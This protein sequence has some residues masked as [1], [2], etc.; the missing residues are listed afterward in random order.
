MQHEPVKLSADSMADEGHHLRHIKRLYAVRCDVNRAMTRRLGRQE[1]VRE[2]CRILVEVGEFRFACF[3]FSAAGGGIP[4]ATYGDIPEGMKISSSSHGP[5]RSHPP[6]LGSAAVA[7][8]PVQ[9]PSGESGSLVLSAATTDF[10][11]D[12][13]V[14]LLAEI[15]ADVEYALEFAESEARRAAVEESMERERSLFKT[16]VGTI[17]DLVW[18]KDPDGTYLYCNPAFERFFGASLKE[19]VGRSDY[20]FVDAEL[21]EFFRM[22]DREALATDRPTKNDEWVTFPDDGHRALL[23]T[24]KSPLRDGSGRLVGVLGIARDVTDTRQVAELEALLDQN[25]RFRAIFDA[26]TEGIVVVDTETLLQVMVNP[27]ACAM[28]GYT[29]E[30]FLRLGVAGMHPAALL[31]AVMSEFRELV[32]GEK[33]G[34]TDIP[35][36][37]R[38]GAIF[39]ANVGSGRISL[40][41]R[42]CLMG[43]FSDI[44]GR[45]RAE[46]ELRDSEQKFRTFSAM[47]MDGIV[48]LDGGGRVTYWNH[49]AEHIFGFSN[50]EVMGHHLHPLIVPRDQGDSY[51]RGLEQFDRTGTGPLIDKTYE[52]RA[53]HKNGGEFP[54]EV[55]ISGYQLRGRW[56]AVGIIRDITRRKRE[57]AVLHEQAELLRTGQESLSGIIFGANLGTWELNLQNGA[58][59]LNQRWAEMI[60]YTLEEL[61]PTGLHTLRE[62]TH[63]DDFKRVLDCFER[64]ING[65]SRS[66]E[67]E[68]RMRHKVGHWVWIHDRGKIVSRDADGRPLLASGT[69]ADISKRKKTEQALAASEQSLFDIIA[70]AH[71]GTWEWNL[72]SGAAKFNERWAEMIGYRLEELEPNKLNTLKKHTHLEDLPHVLELFDRHL[73]GELERFECEY[74]MRHKEGGWVWVLDRGRVVSR[75]A[76]GR[77]LLASGTHM[78]ITPRKQAEAALAASEKFM[79]VLTDFIPGMVG[80]WTSDLRCGFANIAY[81]EWFGRSPEEM[82]NLPI[83]DLLGE[84]I[85]LLNKPF[86]TAALRGERQSFQRTLVKVDGSIS[87]VW[88]HYI[89]SL[90]GNE[91]RGF[92]VLVS[93]VTE[94]KQAQVQLEQVNRDLA[95]RTVEAEAA[96]RAKSEFLA[97]MSHEIRT[98]MNAV[99]GLGNLALRTESSSKRED[100]L[101]KM[102]TAAKGLQQLLSDLL[103]FSK[104]EAGK[105][106]VVEITFLLFPLMQ[107]LVDLM[108]G[109]AEERGIRLTVT[110]DPAIP[111]CLVGDSF[112]L[113]QV[114]VNLVGN[115]I[116]FT[117]NG[118]VSLELR[119][120]PGTGEEFVIEFTVR[121]SGIGMT[122]EQLAGIFEPFIQGDGSTT[123]TYGGTGLGL[124]IC[125]RLVHLMKGDIQA[126]SKPGEGSCFTFTT[127]VMAGNPVDLRNAVSPERFD[128]SKPSSKGNVTR[129]MSEQGGVMDTPAGDGDAGEGGGAYSMAGDQPPDSAAVAALLER[130]RVL[131]KK[132]SIQAKT[133]LPSLHDLLQ[134]TGLEAESRRI[135]LSLE[136]FDFRRARSLV[137]NLVASLGGATVKKGT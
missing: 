68:F 82:R 127:Q 23:E 28:F 55:S 65:E 4:E 46:E 77:P 75:D 130:L 5:W 61:G 102:T 90:E 135:E 91:V 26:A 129:E 3:G 85:Y 30:E 14:T 63:P 133:L 89:P 38:D 104:I 124:S 125:R 8:F 45:L 92:F 54:A 66:Y 52:Y 79:R 116:K 56:Q 24:V 123:R 10:F 99:I 11:S 103:D 27:A 64:H 49:A 109:N 119:L 111:P 59:V 88:A 87:H 25:R 1:L 105:L 7:G 132:N 94:L 110:V 62:H 53:R 69:H 100:Y 57:E 50:D 86:I 126:V 108:E 93:D 137:E 84:E 73:H 32:S 136:K 43:F 117:E 35:C 78:D 33:T 115:A 97:N 67:C 95:Q 121:D 17:P 36:L 2:L 51:L 44:T 13:E 15:C 16:L 19:I 98:P 118:E 48:M 42:P 20:D 112:R 37:R 18:L 101:T 80:Y 131:L 120:L 31:P 74:R 41:G 122:P 21:A 29:E 96:N 40:Q 83:H 81:R 113:K 12:D 70:G 39:F 106:N 128:A 76:D 134:G 58:G 114:L 6:D 60:G 9:L 71:L 47:A 72:Q 22:K 107:Q 34:L